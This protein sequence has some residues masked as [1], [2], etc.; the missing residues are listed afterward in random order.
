M[1]LRIISDIHEF[2]AFEGKWSQFLTAC[3][4]DDFFLSHIWINTYLRQ[5]FNGHRLRILL[6]ETENGIISAAPLGI[7]KGSVITPSGWKLPIVT[8]TLHFIGDGH[9]PRCDFPIIC[10]SEAVVGKFAEYAV[11][12]TSEWE[13]I[14]LRQIPS[15]SPNLPFLENAFSRLGFEVS[16]TKDAICPYRHF[17]NLSGTEASLFSPNYSK[18]LHRLINKGMKELKSSG[19]VEV[20]VY[21]DCQPN[22]IL[23]S[24]IAGIESGSWKRK[25]KHR[26]FSE[27]MASFT[28]ELIHAACNTSQL[29][30]VTL[31]VDDAP[32]AYNMGFIYRGKYYSYSSAYKASYTHYKPGYILHR[33]V[34]DIMNRMNMVEHDFLM[35]DSRYK[36]SFCNR[37]RQNY[38]VRVFNDHP[39]SRL[40]Y[41]LYS[42][43]RQIYKQ[44]K[45]Y[46]FTRSNNGSSRG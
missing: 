6:F 23:E 38:V 12:H 42:G 5:K 35:G 24:C 28:A 31:N 29:F 4:N 27:D 7:R 44:A 19:K 14:E 2:L 21:H 3:I 36:Q 15:T 43:L 40:L 46:L 17:D 16:I 41:G 13:M 39:V 30:F 1:N 18:R 22:T 34:I 45:E 25:A 11:A 8:R 37:V 10:D 26:L 9:S 32:V 33:E 20:K